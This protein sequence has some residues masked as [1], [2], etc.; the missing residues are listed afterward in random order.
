MGIVYAG[1]LPNAQS[2]AAAAAP[3]RTVTRALAAF[4]KTAI[5][6]AI[7]S[8]PHPDHYLGLLAIDA[9]IRELWAAL[10]P[11]AAPAD[12]AGFGAV[13]AQLALRGTRLVT[14]EL[15]RH[16]ATAGVELEVL[17]PR[18]DT[19]PLAAADPVRTVNDNSLVVVVRYAGRS[20]LFAGDLELEGEEGLVH[21]PNAPLGHVDV[22]KVPHHG[23][24]TSSSPGFVAATHPEL[25]VISCGVANLFG[26]PSGEVV[27]RWQAGGARVERTDL[28][29]TITVTVSR[30]GEL[31]VERFLR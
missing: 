18:Y 17:W 13:T 29:G 30:S 8:H 9:P 24:R 5:D 7:I 27:H 10:P 6:R 3:G 15:G 12:R 23:S 11:D 21:G 28:G 16:V 19:E 31:R 20:L 25:A 4:G 26:F 2:P 1:G 14:P 22:V